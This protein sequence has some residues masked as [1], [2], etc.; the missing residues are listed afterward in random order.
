MAV[1]D[2]KVDA[3]GIDHATGSVVLTIL[4]AQD[5]EDEREHL[6]ALQAKVNAYFSYIQ[7]RELYEDYPQ[8]DG[9]PVVI[10]IIQRLDPPEAFERFLNAANDVAAPLDITITAQVFEGGS[11]P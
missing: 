10:N 3:V 8:T 9:R 1:S 2:Q 5:W 6:L 4:D 7:G 11:A